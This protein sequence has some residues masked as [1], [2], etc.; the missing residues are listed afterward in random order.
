MFIG[1]PSLAEP[2]AIEAILTTINK[3]VRMSPNAEVTLEVNPT[4]GQL[5]KLK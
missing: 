4:S 5:Q 2:F 1:T 3:H